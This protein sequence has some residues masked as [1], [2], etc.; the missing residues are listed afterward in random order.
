MKK[1]T[2]LA[3]MLCSSLLSC[4][5]IASESNMDRETMISN[6]M[7]DKNYQELKDAEA[8]YFVT[9]KKEI[10]ASVKVDWDLIKKRN[11]KSKKE[12]I[13]LCRDAGMKNPEKYVEAKIRMMY[14]MAK[15]KKSHPELKNL[16]KNLRMDI[17]SEAENRYQK[18]NINS[19]N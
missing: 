9:E 8:D 18:Q 15:V 3:F 6:L 5:D 12:Y 10:Q 11:P 19:N 4:K 1:I 17:F 14:F 7:K 13:N 2:I 16:S